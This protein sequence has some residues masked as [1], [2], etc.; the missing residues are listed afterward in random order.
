MMAKG[1]DSKG[2]ADYYLQTGKNDYYRPK[3][4]EAS[5]PGC[6]GQCFVALYYISGPDGSASNDWQ[7]MTVIS[8][9][10]GTLRQIAT[11]QVGQRGDRYI[12]ITGID[13]DGIHAN[14]LVHPE[15]AGMAELEPGG[16]VVFS[17]DGGSL[18]EHA[19]N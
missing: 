9:D 16:Q 7:L 14:L 19:D 6:P 3:V 2:F 8:Q 5:L 4:Y 17:I 18:V 1:L 13:S 15:H 11:K 12:N 10:A